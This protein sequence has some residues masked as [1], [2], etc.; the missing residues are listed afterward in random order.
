MP[1]TSRPAMI[2]G[3]GRGKLRF[4]LVKNVSTSAYFRSMTPDENGWPS[5]GPNKR[6][7]GALP[8]ET[9]SLDGTF[10]S[11]TGG[12][13]VSPKSPWHIPQHRR[14]RGMGRGSTG[15]DKDW[16]FGIDNGELHAAFLAVRLDPQNAQRHAFVEPVTTITLLEYNN[17]L[18]STQRHWRRAW[19]QDLA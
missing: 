12:M 6:K 18:A 11:G 2:T 19:P 4:G 14:P 8:S 1:K 15:P 3:W 17:S 10:G 5:T 9:N 13:S 16:V 7:L